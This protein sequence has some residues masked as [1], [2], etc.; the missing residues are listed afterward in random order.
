MNI[1]M[2]RTIESMKFWA[3]LLIGCFVLTACSDSDDGPVGPT[4]EDEVEEMLSK[5][6]LRE[7]VGQLFFIRPESLDPNIHWVDPTELAPYKLQ[8]VNDDMKNRNK[9]YPVVACRVLPTIPTS[10]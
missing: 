2:N 6:T 8:A 4:P 10:T 1:T 3:A 7:K 5:M 9:N